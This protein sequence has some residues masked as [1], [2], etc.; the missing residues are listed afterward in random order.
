MK[1]TLNVLL[2][3]DFESDAALIEIELR[4]GG[5]EPNCTRVQTAGEMNRALAGGTW[6]AIICDYTLPHFSGVQALDYLHRT[7]LD[8]P[9]IIVSGTISEDT[10]VAA[11]KAGAHD[12]VMKDN[13]A[14]LVPAVR[15]E[16]HEAAQRR[17]F[18]EMQE[19]LRQAE[20]LK[21]VGEL[22]ASIIH[23]LSN[24]LQT[25]LGLA[26]ALKNGQLPDEKR[27]K[28]A[29]TIEREV[30]LIV[31]M[32]RDILEFTRG[33]L[34]ISHDV[35]DIASLVREFVETYSPV[36]AACGVTLSW[37]ISPRA[38]CAPVIDG[39]SVKLR[40][41]LQNLLTNARDAMPSGGRVTLGVSCDDSSV[42][43]EV[44]DNGAGIPQEIRDSL[45][46]PFVSQ[47]KSEGTGLGLAIVKQIVESHGGTVSFVTE[48]CVGTTFKLTFPR[49]VSEDVDAL[50]GRK[51]SRY[52]GV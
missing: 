19:Q 11:M 13:M 50:T 24:P 42:A 12:Y 18:A 6:D 39:D 52:S 2:V 30:E 33:K 51:R 20:R 8:I 29:D 38:G 46:T 16:L 36:C 21:S 45:F 31:G 25:I 40:R 26:E 10:A 17:A 22:M 34:Q 14:R 23:D 48:E 28:H 3:E 41:V 44:T 32:R 37:S 49:A 9:F 15:R 47:G 27:A 1:P 35:I 4:R 7:G 5:F 43:I